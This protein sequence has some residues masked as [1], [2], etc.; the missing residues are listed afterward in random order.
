LSEVRVVTRQPSPSVARSSCRRISAEPARAVRYRVGD[1]SASPQMIACTR[2]LMVGRNIA[3]TAIR[4]GK[5]SSRH[6][7]ARRIHKRPSGLRRALQASVSL[8]PLVVVLCHPRASSPHATDKLRCARSR[9]PKQ[10]SCQHRDAVTLKSNSRPPRL[11]ESAWLQQADRR[12]AVA[13]KKP[14]IRIN[15]Q[16]VH[17]GSTAG[18]LGA[19][20]AVGVSLRH[21]LRN[22]DARTGHGW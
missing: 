22:S 20:R 19:V 1:S 2:S 11:R 5:A 4:C 7:I 15:I 9:P 17:G 6:Q 3:L 12:L 21:I 13:L 10:H 14:A 18:A 8:R 16:A